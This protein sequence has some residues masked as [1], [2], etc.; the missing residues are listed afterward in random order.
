MRVEP[1]DSGE[2][3]Y[4]PPSRERM[5]SKRVKRLDFAHLLDEEMEKTPFMRRLESL[6]WY[7]WGNDHER[8]MVWTPKKGV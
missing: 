8:Q 7:R 4:R 5:K 6:R 3:G 2:S 1:V